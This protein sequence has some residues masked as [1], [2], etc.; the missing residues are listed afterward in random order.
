MSKFHNSKE[1]QRLAKAHK[2]LSCSDC[3]SKKDIQSGHILPASRFKMMSLWKSN[4]IAQCLPCN[5]KLGAKIHWSLQAIKLLV[6]YG[7]IKLIMY[8]SLTL[9]IVILC[10]FIYLDVY[11]NAST[12]TNQM[13]YELLAFI[14]SLNLT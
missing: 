2:Q 14:D 8:L 12:I 7:M 9:I 3:G 1:W 6:I 5:R 4:L 11:Y 13:H 10:R